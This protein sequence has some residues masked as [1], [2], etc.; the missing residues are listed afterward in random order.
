VD[1]VLGAAV[2]DGERVVDAAGDAV[3]RPV[4]DLSILSSTS[5]F[6]YTP[7][8]CK[9]PGPDADNGTSE[10]VWPE[11]MCGSGGVSAGHPLVTGQGSLPFSIVP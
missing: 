10:A 5:V 9:A 6:S 3:S 4:D 2:D 7:V 1:G 11:M 8:N